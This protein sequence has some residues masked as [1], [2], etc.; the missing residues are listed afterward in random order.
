MHLA[1]MSFPQA[2]GANSAFGF[3]PARRSVGCQG[4]VPSLP[5]IRC[6]PSESLSSSAATSKTGTGALERDKPSKDSS[7]RKSRCDI[8]DVFN[9]LPL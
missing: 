3:V 9:A 6:S 8:E 7:Q 1:A 5:S 2:M 4:A